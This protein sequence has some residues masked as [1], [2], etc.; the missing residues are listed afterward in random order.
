MIRAQYP[1]R[2]LTTYLQ[3]NVDTGGS[4]SGR[5]SVPFRAKSRE[6]FPDGQLVTSAEFP[7]FFSG[8]SA[9]NRR[10]ITKNEYGA[11]NY[12][13]PIDEVR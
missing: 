3:G 5:N 4:R 2:K 10:K 9:E 12:S 6:F 8:K 7:P 1:Y 11:E 13:L